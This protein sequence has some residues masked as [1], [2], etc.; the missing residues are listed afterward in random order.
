MSLGLP[1]CLTCIDFVN[2]DSCQMYAGGT[3]SD[4]GADRQLCTS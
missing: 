1:D 3:D 2:L 4:H